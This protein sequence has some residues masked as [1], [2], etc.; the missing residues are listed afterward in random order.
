MSDHYDVPQICL[1]GHVSNE[2]I[3][4]FPEDNRKFCD[5]CGE[6]TMTA[7]QGCHADIRGP[8]VYANGTM[9]AANPHTTDPWRVPLFCE[10]CGNPYPWTE[11]RL[12]A[13]KE[14]IDQEQTLA[15]DEKDALEADINA[16]TR[17]LPRTRAAAIRI[18]GFLAKTS[19][20]VGSALRDIVVDVASEAAKQILL[21]P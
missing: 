6:P 13:A 11:R 9:L 16:I 21:G 15:A 4:T 7:C 2:A 5:R 12:Q 18:K 8:L 10:N 17:D 20:A 1:S 14:L 3:R 19:G